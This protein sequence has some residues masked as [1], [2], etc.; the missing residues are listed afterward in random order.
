VAVGAVVLQDIAYS[1]PRP[2]TAPP[3]CAAWPP[4]VPPPVLAHAWA[5]GRALTA[6]EAVVR[7]PDNWHITIGPASGVLGLWLVSYSLKAVV[8]MEE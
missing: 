4:F 6:G 1:A 2:P 3:T 8:I 5:A 7:W